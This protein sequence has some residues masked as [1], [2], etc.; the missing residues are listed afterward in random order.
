[1]SKTLSDKA[2]PRVRLYGTYT[3]PLFLLVLRKTDGNKEYK[4]TLMLKFSVKNPKQNIIP[5]RAMVVAKTHPCMKHVVDLSLSSVQSRSLS[6][7]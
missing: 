3:F 6:N 2:Y 4:L 7:M 5:H 1:M